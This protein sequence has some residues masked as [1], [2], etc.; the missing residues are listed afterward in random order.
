MIGTDSV[1]E[2]QEPV[3]II[4]RQQLLVISLTIYLG[5]TASLSNLS[6]E[7]FRNG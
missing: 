4:S 6:E 1:I 5:E 7:R 2:V 3:P